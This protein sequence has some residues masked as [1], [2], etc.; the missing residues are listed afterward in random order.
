[1]TELKLEKKELKLAVAIYLFL[2][3]KV[4]I[5]K[6]AEI[7]S[8]SKWDFIDFLS[9]LGIPVVNYPEEELEDEARD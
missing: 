2:T 6:A 9:E 4:S 8:M 5:G 1:M 3:K 7:A